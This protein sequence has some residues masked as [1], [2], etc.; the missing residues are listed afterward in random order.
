VL[1]Y[2]GDTDPMIRAAW[3]E[4][5]VAGLGYPEATDPATGANTGAWAPWTYPLDADGAALVGGYVTSYTVPSG[6]PAVAAAKPEAKGGGLDF[7]TI[8]GSGHM[9]PQNQPCAASE[10]FGKWVAGQPFTLWDTAATTTEVAAA[11]LRSSPRSAPVTAL[12]GE[13]ASRRRVWAAK[14]EAMEA[15]IA[16]MKSRG[17]APEGLV[18]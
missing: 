16:A 1:I 10:F 12:E 2:A 14:G 3:S 8:R 13:L 18:H 5:W 6:E 7:L 15:A 11:A 17:A 4:Q 9:V